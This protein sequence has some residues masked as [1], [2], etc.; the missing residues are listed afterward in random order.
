MKYQKY[1]LGNPKIGT[2]ES[3]LYKNEHYCQIAS[4]AFL[5]AKT[6]QFFACGGLTIT[7]ALVLAVN[8]KQNFSVG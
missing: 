1:V 8:N 6:Q 2:F 7:P 5:Y 4:R 3:Y